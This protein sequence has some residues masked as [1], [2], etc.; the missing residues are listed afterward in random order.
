MNKETIRII[1]YVIKKGFQIN[2]NA[3]KMIN[4]L[5]QNNIINILDEIITTK[6]EKHDF[7]IDEYD[8]NKYTNTN[9][10]I[11][12]KLVVLS[13]PT[14]Y[15]TSSEGIE[16]YHA[17]FKSRFIKF[18]RITKQRKIKINTITELLDSKKEMYV[19][20]L[21]Y[22]RNIEK[23]FT[24]LVVDDLSNLINVIV[25]D[26]NIKNISD[27]LLLDQFI[28]LKAKL[29]KNND[30]VCN[31][32]IHLDIPEH[33]VNKSA[34]DSH[35]VFLSDLHIGSKY[36]MEKE[37][38][39]FISWLKSAEP[40]VKKIK[41]IIIAGDLIDGVGIYQNQDKE[42]L[43]DTIY[44]QIEKTIDVLSLI[45]K[46]IQIIISPGNHDPGRKA[47]PQ[48]ALTNKL[49]RIGDNV[50]LVGNPSLISLNGVKILIFHGQ[51]IDDIVKV[52]PGLSYNKPTNVMKLMLRSRHLGTIYGERTPLAPELN[53]ML[54]IDEIPDIFHTGH[55]HVTDF[56]SY[57]GVLLINSGAWQKQTPFQTSV[58]ITPTPG[59]ASIVNLKTFKIYLN[60][61]TS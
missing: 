21:L 34:T 32:I 49:Q 15:I 45:P 9:N 5:E 38:N 40:I 41:F 54:V 30:Y 23:K 37:L 18:K 7:F 59:I 6:I 29:W 19:C 53:D 48:P 60:N 35:V 47:L 2:P 20:G 36:F 55:V 16:G 51:S 56:D 24:K 50:V 46:N 3:L 8:F 39:K 42:L 28:V 12:S 57:R 43:L 27:S 17:L 10:L 25:F 13:D 52:V 11:E 26:S 4:K 14:D 44:K 1:N 61:F 58:G 33:T 31:E 22:D